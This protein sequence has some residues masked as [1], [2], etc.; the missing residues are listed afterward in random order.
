MT[1]ECVDIRLVTPS[2]LACC[3]V[4]HKSNKKKHTLQREK[5]KKKEKVT[6]SAL[7]RGR[8]RLKNIGQTIPNIIFYLFFPISSQTEYNNNKQLWI[9]MKFIDGEERVE[10]SFI[11]FCLGVCF[12]TLNMETSKM[13]IFNRIRQQQ[14]TTSQKWHKKKLKRKCSFFSII[15]CTKSYRIQAEA[16][17]NSCVTNNKERKQKKRCSIEMLSK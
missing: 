14:Q 17:Q 1:T 12:L 5:N 11:F 9:M 13:K 2:R 10:I 7:E 15:R 8:L 16:L 6:N 3:C 4:T